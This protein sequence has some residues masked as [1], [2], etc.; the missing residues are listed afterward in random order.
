[1]LLAAWLAK[2]ASS[3]TACFPAQDMIAGLMKAYREKSE[4]AL[5]DK[6]QRWIARIYVNR[7]SESWSIVVFRTDG[8]ACMIMT[9]VG[10]DRP[11]KQKPGKPL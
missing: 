3:Q 8:L 5:L 10:F 7:D 1:M 11:A 6:D 2:P 9:G 4:L